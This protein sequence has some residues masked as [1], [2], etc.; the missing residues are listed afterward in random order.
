[1]NNTCLAFQTSKTTIYKP[2]TSEL[3]SISK[4]QLRV[5]LEELW[6]IYDFLYSNLEQVKQ[7]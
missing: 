1:M 6:K 5:S 7:K 3:K 4:F 2:Q